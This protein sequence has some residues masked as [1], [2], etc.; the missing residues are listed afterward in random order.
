MFENISFPLFLPISK[1]LKGG[2]FMERAFDPA[3]QAAALQEAADRLQ[4]L[5]ESEV[6][7]PEGYSSGISPDQGIAHTSSEEDRFPKVVDRTKS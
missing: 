7:F 5:R 6:P 1:Y 2:D 3:R 4:G